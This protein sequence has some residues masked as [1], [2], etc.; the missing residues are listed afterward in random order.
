MDISGTSTRWKWL[1]KSNS[2]FSKIQC[3]F[4]DR[5]HRESAP[6]DAKLPPH[7][8]SRM[9]RAYGS[10]LPSVSFQTASA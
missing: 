7:S 3:R 8:V 4:V 5:V 1:K 10:H 9:E 6:A 2:D